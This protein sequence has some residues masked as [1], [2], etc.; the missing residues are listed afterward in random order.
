MT[1]TRFQVS[2]VNWQLNRVSQ[3]E[4]TTFTEFSYNNYLGSFN[5]NDNN[6]IIK[7][8]S[9]LPPH[10]SLSVRFDLL[11]INYHQSND[12]VKINMDSNSFIYT[13][14][15]VGSGYSICH[16]YNANAVQYYEEILLFYQNI[17][18]QSSTLNINL[19][20]QF[21]WEARWQ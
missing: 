15:S 10:W 9:N 14:Q 20:A 5:R 3:C 18:H 1:S 16:N 21:S 17:T 6:Q 19:Q 8:V 2:D 4:Q 12:Y 11:L 7:I 13:K